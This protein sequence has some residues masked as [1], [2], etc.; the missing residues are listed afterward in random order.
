MI[1]GFQNEKN[2]KAKNEYVFVFRLVDSIGIVIGIPYDTF[3]RFGPT[4]QP[5]RP[6]RDWNPKAIA[7]GEKMSKARRMGNV[8]D[9]ANPNV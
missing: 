6:L 2:Y 8:P 4:C 3:P 5:N 1:I 9:A 7:V